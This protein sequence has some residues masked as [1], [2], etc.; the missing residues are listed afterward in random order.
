MNAT[1]PLKVQR[2]LEQDEVQVINLDGIVLAVAEIT[3]ISKHADRQ[4]I[5]GQLLGGDPRVGQPTMTPH[6]SRNSVYYP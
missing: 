3:G 2:V 1:A 6:P 5:Q 4:A